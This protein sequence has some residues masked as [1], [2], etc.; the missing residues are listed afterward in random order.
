[1]GKQVK[2]ISYQD[3]QMKNEETVE[4]I[5]KLKKENEQ[6][7]GEVVKEKLCREKDLE[8]ERDRLQIIYQ[9][10]LEMEIAGFLE[11]LEKVK[12][13]VSKD[14]NELQEKLNESIFD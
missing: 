1:M 4:D 11:E 10:D 2:I 6:F 14:R 7:K 8:R 12:Q 9:K 3:L 13:V 5:E